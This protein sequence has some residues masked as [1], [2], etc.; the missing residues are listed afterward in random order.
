M[1]KVQGP[2]KNSQLMFGK[3]QTTKGGPP[4][5]AN[6]EN[7]G[8][9]GSSFTGSA[10]PFAKG[11]LRL[12]DPEGD[13]TGTS[14]GQFEGRFY[15]GFSYADTENLQGDPIDFYAGWI[16]LTLGQDGDF[17]SLTIDRWAYES[18]PNQAA[19]IPG[20]TPVPGAGGLLALALG[21]AG[22]RRRRE[23]VA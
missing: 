11:G 22:I 7:L 6:F 14:F 8:Q 10:F 19:S 16:E 9:V 3:S 13:K 1:W 20:G 23:R 18:T 5:L 21:A 12:I 4:V 15:V 17:L 2:I